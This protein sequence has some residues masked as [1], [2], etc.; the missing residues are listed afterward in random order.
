LQVIEETCAILSAET[1]RTINRDPIAERQKI[2]LEIIGVVAEVCPWFSICI[3][4]KDGVN[5]RDAFWCRDI[6]HIRAE[7]E[8]VISGICWI[9]IQFLPCVRWVVEWSTDLNLS[10]SLHIYHSGLGYVL[11]NAIVAAKSLI[12]E[13]SSSPKISFNY[14]MAFILLVA[15]SKSTLSTRALILAM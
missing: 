13:S 5:S 14:W 2:I 7:V 11:G 12:S 15:N 9:P 8:E 4:G 6:G 3:I 1:S 10:V